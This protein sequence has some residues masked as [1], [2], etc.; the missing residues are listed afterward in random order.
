MLPLFWPFCVFEIWANKLRERT[1]MFSEGLTM[2]GFDNNN[3]NRAQNSS[4][5]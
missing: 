4:P 1:I 3:S 5:N 2:L